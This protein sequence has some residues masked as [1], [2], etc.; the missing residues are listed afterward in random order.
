M[1]SLKA[2]FDITLPNF[3]LTMSLILPGEGVTAMFGPSR[4]RKNN[5][6]A[7]SGGTRTL[8]DRIHAIRWCHLARRATRRVHSTTQTISRIRLPRSQAVSSSQRRIESSIRI[9]ADSGNQAIHQLGP[10]RRS[11]RPSTVTAPPYASPLRGRT[12]TGSNRPRGI[13]EPTSLTDG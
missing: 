1:S 6:P 4:L 13:G 10:C 3:R 7:L 11:S 2:Q 8:A 5:D 9:H 12:T